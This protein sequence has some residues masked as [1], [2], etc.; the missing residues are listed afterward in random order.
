M[1]SQSNTPRRRIFEYDGKFLPSKLQRELRAAS[2]EC[3]GVTATEDGG[4]D[5]IAVQVICTHDT[6]EEQVARVVRSHDPTALSVQPPRPPRK[7][8]IS[9]T[10]LLVL[11]LALVALVAVGI[12]ARF[13]AFD[14]WAPNIATEAL[15]ILVTVAVVERIVRRE[16][17]RRVA[18]RR[19]RAL[20]V[21]SNAVVRFSMNASGDYLVTHLD[22]AVPPPS[23]PVGILDGWLLGYGNEDA[24]RRPGP[25]GLSRFVDD[26]VELIE[27]TQR[28]IDSD[29]DVLPPD[30]VV[31]A[32]NLSVTFGG[33][34]DDFLSLIRQPPELRPPEGWILLCLMHPARHFA[35]VLSRYNGDPRFRCES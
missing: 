24:P 33:M 7:R 25:G 35:E 30:L 2:V 11:A 4:G 9:D 1:K 29:R 28:V 23:D 18:P 12:A 32:D 14:N 26:C 34:G 21:L 8:V 13:N 5:V 22:N 10:A 20:A 17:E 15:S 31:A 6:N 19:E 27:R 16:S 3:F